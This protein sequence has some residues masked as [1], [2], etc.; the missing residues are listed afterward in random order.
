MPSEPEVWAQ[1]PT[2]P[3]SIL[4]HWVIVLLLAGAFAAGG[5]AIFALQ[6]PVY[7]A[8]AQLIFS[9]IEVQWIV[10]EEGEPLPTDQTRQLQNRA[11]YIRSS[12]VVERAAERLGPG[13]DPATLH[14]S[15]DVWM[16]P[17]ISDVITIVA[18]ASNPELAADVANAIGEAYQE[19][20][21]GL[22]QQRAKEARAE[23]DRTIERLQTRL[24]GFDLS[25][26]RPGSTSPA[27][28]RRQAARTQLV[29]LTTWRER[30]TLATDLASAR[31]GSFEP[32]SPPYEPV[33]PRPKRTAAGGLML[34]AA[35]GSAFAYWREGRGGAARR[36]EQVRELL[37]VPLLAQVP[38]RSMRRLPRP[39][40]PAN[41][42]DSA[43]GQ[44]EFLGVVLDRY[45]N[46]R[47]G[48]TVLVTAVRR[49]RDNPVIAL[50]VAFTLCN[51]D[52]PVVLVDADLRGRQLTRLF[53]LEDDL[54]LSDLAETIVIAERLRTNGALFG[55]ETWTFVP[56]GTPP[57]DSYRMLRSRNF[58]RL[59]DEIQ[60]DG[61]GGRSARVVLR[62]PPVLSV[63]DAGTL[64]VLADG[65]VLQVARGTPLEDIQQAEETL[66]MAGG[67][68]VGFVF[69][70]GRPWVFQR[71]RWSTADTPRRP[72]VAAV[73]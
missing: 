42:I 23:L 20:A 30:L 47:Q 68:L 6:D 63:A 26:A 29:S 65:V 40:T 58:V 19:L 1:G 41:L 52:C 72:P 51:D 33:A 66:R 45:M 9:D 43:G 35:L 11:N 31:V 36:P 49:R 22:E 18:R 25:D 15:I 53:Q 12:E 56:A 13:M 2:L 8:H 27:D 5:Y 67:S 38:R 55:H 62:G 61:P 24:E 28:L 7:E 10:R 64:A 46:V 4:R 14:D 70:D 60:R 34:G 37:G 3:S 21:E 39:T 44:Y 48:G 69:E 59:L 17:E 50:N 73:R 54:G 57:L 71:R 16:D 32:A